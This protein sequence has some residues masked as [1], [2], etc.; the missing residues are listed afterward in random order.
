MAG[1]DIEEDAGGY[2]EYTI[3]EAAEE[4]FSGLVAEPDEGLLVD[5]RPLVG[6]HELGQRVLVA[7]AAA[8]DDDAGSVVIPEGGTF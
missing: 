6:A 8:L 3:E 1:V 2:I 7:G 5:Q 4:D